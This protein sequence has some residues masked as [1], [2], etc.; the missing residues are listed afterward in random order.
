[1]PEGEGQHHDEDA[2]PERPDDALVEPGLGGLG[3]EGAR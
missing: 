3:A 2:D 1:M